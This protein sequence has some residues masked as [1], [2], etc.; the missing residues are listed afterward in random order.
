ML[1]YNLKVFHALYGL[2]T[3]KKSPPKNLP[4][5]QLKSDKLYCFTILTLFDSFL[6]YIYIYIYIYCTTSTFPYDKQDPSVSELDFT[7][8][9][10]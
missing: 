5:S 6:V 1:K 8:S 4:R 3:K 10:L 9:L 2:V 7:S